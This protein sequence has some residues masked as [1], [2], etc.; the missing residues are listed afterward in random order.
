M[1]R[2]KRLVPWACGAL[3]LLVIGVQVAICAGMLWLQTRPPRGAYFA[4]VDRVE[5]EIPGLIVRA[6]TGVVGEIE[7]VN[8][9]R[10]NVYLFDEEGNEVLKIT[11][12]GVFKKNEHEHWAPHGSGNW[13]VLGG[14]HITHIS[15]HDSITSPW[16]AYF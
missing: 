3:L 9:T 16:F 7:I 5:P 12:T 6:T 11:A 2:L 10:Q 15:Y 13:A 1:E 4:V 14:E 8:N